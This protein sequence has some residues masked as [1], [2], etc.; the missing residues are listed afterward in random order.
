MSIVDGQNVNASNTNAAYVSKTDTTGNNVPGKINLTNPETESVA[1]VTN[2]QKIINQESTVFRSVQTVTA[3]GQI[4]IDERI[5]NH[6]VLVVGDAGNVT[7]STTPFDAENGGSFLDG[8]I[9]TVIGT[10]NT[11]SVTIANA[12]G[13]DGV[14]SNGDI[15]LQENQ[16]RTYIRVTVSG[17]RY[18]LHKV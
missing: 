15:E 14:V 9:I 6:I 1:T 17:I 4:T 5:K 10:N 7:A 18:W 8:T 12:A 16:N 11:Q 3:A 13:A 2:V